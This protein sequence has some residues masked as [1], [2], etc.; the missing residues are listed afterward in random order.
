MYEKSVENDHP[1]QF[2]PDHL[3]TQGPCNKT[4]NHRL[5]QLEYVPHCFKTEEMCNEAV[6]VDPCLLR[7][8]PDHFKT[9]GMCEKAVEDEPE[10]LKYVPDYFKTEEMCK[11]AVRREP[12]SLKCL[13]EYVSDWFVTH[14]QI[15][16][17][18]D[19]DY[20]CYDDELI[21]WY[22]GYRKRKAQ[23]TSIKEELMPITW[24]PSRYWDWCMSED[25]KKET[26]KLWS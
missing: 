17:W 3:R 4:V 26:E 24:H 1:L 23:K 13:L 25:E 9:E 6:K 22:K 14:Q 19:N 20:W 12:Y 5:W 21:E 7:L 16:I 18:H 10:T 15:K 2:T 11:E 8:I